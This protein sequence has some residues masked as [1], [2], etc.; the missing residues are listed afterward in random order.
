MHRRPRARRASRGRCPARSTPR[1][2]EGIARAVVSS[3]PPAPKLRSTAIPPLRPH[4]HPYPL[5]LLRPSPLAPRRPSPRRP[6]PAVN[7]HDIETTFAS[8]PSPYETPGEVYLYRHP[9]LSSPAAIAANRH[10]LK[11]GRT[12]DVERRESEWERQCALLARL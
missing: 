6:M 7:W 10:Y 3:T 2:T 4:P 1:R 8:L 11:V 9:D 12:N 5:R